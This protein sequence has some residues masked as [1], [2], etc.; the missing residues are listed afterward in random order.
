MSEPISSCPATSVGSQSHSV[1]DAIRLHEQGR[2][3][4]AERIY[5]ALLGV[6]GNNYDVL[7]QLGLLRAQQGQHN[8][9]VALLQHAIAQDPDTVDGHSSL[10]EVLVAMGRNE[11]AVAA[12]DQALAIDSEDPI[13]HYNRGT[14]LQALDRHA[15]AVAAY[16]Q[17]IAIER[18]FPAAHY[19]LGAALQAL[20]QLDAAMAA[21]AEAVALKPGYARAHASLA[22]IQAQLG[23]FETAVTGFQKALEIEPGNLISLLGLASAYTRLAR[24]AEAIA[25]FE[26]AVAAKP[27][28]KRA[29][30]G[31]AE[32]HSLLGQ[33]EASIAAFDKALAAEP[34]NLA[35]LLGCAVALEK[36]ARHDEAIACL[37]QAAT[38]EPNDPRAHV[39]LG[40]AMHRHGRHDDAIRH[41]ARALP[42]LPDSGELLNNLGNAL[43]ALGRHEEAV[44]RFQQAIAL[45]PDAAKLHHNFA[46]ALE[47]L[48]RTDEAL[49][50]YERALALQP[51]LVDAQLG[52]G[53]VLREF[54]RFDEAH[55]AFETAIRNVPGKVAAYYGIGVSKRFTADD[56]HLAA[57]E[58]FAREPSSLSDEDWIVLHFALAK[59]YEDLGQYERSFEHLLD[60]NRLKRRQLAYDEANALGIMDRCRNV[61]T[62]EFLREKAGHGDPS[63]VPIFIVGMMRSGSTLVEQ[64]LASHPQVFGGGE[65]PYFEKSLVA[66]LQSIGSRYTPTYLDAI[67]TRDGAWIE[68][69]AS[70]YL[71]ALTATAPAALRITDKLL[72]NFVNVGLIHLALP[73]AR[74]IHTHRDPLDTCLSCF[75][76]LFSAPIPFVYDLPELGRYY[77]SYERLM[78]HWRKVLP[79]GVMID[80]RYEDVVADLEGHARRI[81][82]HC[83]LEWDNACLA[84]HRTERVVRTASLA[85]VRQPLYASSVGRAQPLRAMLH[86]LIEALAGEQAVVPVAV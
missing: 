47:A 48:Q 35:S 5:L 31:L 43:T 39:S 29:H 66:T 60:G 27:D 42:L 67:R 58:A 79:D 76:K 62:S 46:T 64:I 61:F 78:A 34:G 17:A 4:E 52:I 2:W 24:H 14:A 45:M 63:R 85:Q 86:P 81:I 22:G 15:D 69:L 33:H 10:G 73:N 1:E 9:A 6:N 51:N 82:A 13:T 21:Y 83:G 56:P 57:M 23:H 68:P 50:H 44:A 11:E 16:E 3:R 59:A 49:V 70:R 54:G 74:I 20:G 12:C 26:Q 18:A 32:I 75:S 40:D 71:D 80:V 72:G 19:N 30:I 37:E 28:D 41:Y 53:N 7:V 55:H 84:F 36:L 8:A 25:C 38:A 65:R 77:R